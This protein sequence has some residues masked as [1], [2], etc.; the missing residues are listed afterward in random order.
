MTVTLDALT[1]T[2]QAVGLH[3]AVSAV[4]LETGLVTHLE[5]DTGVGALIGDRIYPLQVPQDAELPALAYQIITDRYEVTH[6]QRSELS[7]AR[8]Q[9]THVGTTYTALK[10]LSEAVRDALHQFT[11]DLGGVVVTGCLLDQDTDDW[12]GSH[13]SPVKRSDYIIWYKRIHL[14]GV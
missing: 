4:W 6:D 3:R 1:L 13:K 12:S 2:G 14:M 8:V 9:F 10:S 11:G 5:D 7:R